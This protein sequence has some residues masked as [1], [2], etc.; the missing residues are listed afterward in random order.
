VLRG[1]IKKDDWRFYELTE[2]GFSVAATFANK[3]DIKLAAI[4]IREQIKKAARR[5]R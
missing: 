4:K 5:H 3:S 2:E 1:L